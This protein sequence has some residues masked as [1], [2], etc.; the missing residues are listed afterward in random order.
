MTN[1]VYD[2]GVWITGNPMLRQDDKSLEDWL[3]NCGYNSVDKMEYVFDEHEQILIYNSRSDS[4]CAGNYLAA[5]RVFDNTQY[6]TLRGLPSLLMFVRDYCN[7]L[8]IKG[9]SRDFNNFVDYINRSIQET[10]D[11]D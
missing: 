3:F 8:V 11:D 10:K 7:P 6:I 9:I 2:K 4:F 5:I 1:V